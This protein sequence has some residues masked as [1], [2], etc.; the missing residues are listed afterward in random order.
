MEAIAQ[1]TQGD[2]SHN[3]SRWFSCVTLPKNSPICINTDCWIFAR[4]C[5][6]SGLGSKPSEMPVQLT[7]ESVPLPKIPRQALLLV[8]KLTDS[9]A[10]LGAWLTLQMPLI[11]TVY[12]Q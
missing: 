11:P 2:S 3:L 6:F 4:V 1:D 12:K 7:G 10:V 8:L 9:L 5:W